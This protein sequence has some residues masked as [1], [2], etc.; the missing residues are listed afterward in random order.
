MTRRSRRLRTLVADNYAVL[1]AVLLLVGA[2]GGYVTYATH[3]EPGTTTETR[4]A[5]S[6]RSTL[7][8]SHRARVVNGSEAFAEGTVLRNRSV[9]FQR[10]SPR[11]N[12]SATYAYAASDG[13]ALNATTTIALVFRSVDTGEGENGS[14]Y[15][16][17]ERPVAE[18]TVDSLSPNERTSVP[19]SVNATAAVTEARRIEE[20]LGGSPGT[21]EVALVARTNV[22]GTRNGQPVDATRTNRLRIT[23]DGS[24]FRVEDSEPAV[25][26]D[27]QSERITVPAEYGPIRRLG[28]PLA[29]GV[30]LCGLVGLVAA[31]RTG[32]LTVSEA[33]RQWLAYR[34]TRAEFDEWITTGRVPRRADEPP[35]V[36]V[37]S[38]EGLVD[39][40]IDTDNRVIEDLDRR[41]CLV[42]GREQWFRYDAPEE[43]LDEDA[44]GVD[45]LD[46][47]ADGEG[48]PTDGERPDGHRSD[49]PHPD[50]DA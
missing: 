40:A 44:A 22:S 24:V 31:R 47:D 3:V 39:V 49:E 46:T 38:L 2:V 34:E 17:V 10:V 28:G 16:S 27:S 48:D 4:E 50:G 19:F 1:V 33:E 6:W 21:L 23:A 14:V 13:G 35:T 45:P 41:V 29:L 37:D 36:T 15:W 26:S 43:P 25:A 18:T 9:Y 7:D 8:F 11:L 12:G 42:L 30:G 5:S 20:R 32:R